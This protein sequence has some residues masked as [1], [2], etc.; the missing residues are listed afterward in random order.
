MTHSHNIETKTNTMQ[1]KNKPQSK[2]KKHRL[3]KKQPKSSSSSSLSKHHVIPLEDINEKLEDLTEN[4]T[5]NSVYLH[6]CAEHQN[7]WTY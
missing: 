2:R 4:K 7:L 6:P 3:H 5:K 1:P